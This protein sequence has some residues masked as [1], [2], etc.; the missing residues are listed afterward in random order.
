LTGNQAIPNEVIP[1]THNCINEKN[2][3]AIGFLKKVCSRIKLVAAI[4]L[5]ESRFAPPEEKQM[6]LSIIDSITT[7]SKKEI[8]NKIG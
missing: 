8:Y 2:G 1:K 5:M 7:K 6:V 3:F 4:E